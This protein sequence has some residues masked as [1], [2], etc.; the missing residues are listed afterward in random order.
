MNGEEILVLVLVAGPFLVAIIT[1]M[2]TG[3]KRRHELDK[4]RLDVLKESLQ[5]P[6]IDPATHAELLRVLS[7]EHQ[8]ARRPWTERIGKHTVALRVLWFG[9]SWGLFIVSTGLM[10]A[11]EL[12]VLRGVETRVVLPL[13]IVGFAMVTMPF[14]WNEMRARRDAVAQRR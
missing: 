3:G 9:L 6:A 4:L 10:I 14:A 13:A 2:G 11:G 1:L 7:R 12:R 5:H 8:E